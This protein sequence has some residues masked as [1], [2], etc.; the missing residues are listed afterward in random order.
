MKFS[1]EIEDRNY[2]AKRADLEIE[3]LKEMEDGQID[4]KILSL[5]KIADNLD[6]VVRYL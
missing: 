5:V 6:V 1:R 3:Q 4:I 2:Y